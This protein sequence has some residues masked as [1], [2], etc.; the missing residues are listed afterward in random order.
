MGDEESKET[1][2]LRQQRNEVD[3]YLPTKVLKIGSGVEPNNVLIQ[4]FNGSTGL[5]KG[6]IEI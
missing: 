2:V 3:A 4:R 6:S 1:G 5:I